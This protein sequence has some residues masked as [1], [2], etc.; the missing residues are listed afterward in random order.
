MLVIIV[1]ESRNNSFH[2]TLFLSLL[3]FERL[4]VETLA[5]AEVNHCGTATTGVGLDLTN[6]TQN[7]PNSLSATS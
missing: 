3:Q 5:T 6:A 4:G 7:D 2:W 1:C